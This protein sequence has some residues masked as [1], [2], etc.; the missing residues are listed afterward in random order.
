M[1]THAVLA[2][3]LL[4]KSPPHE[5]EELD[6]RRDNSPMTTIRMVSIYAVLD[7]AT[8]GPKLRSLH[9]ASRHR[10]ARPVGVYIRRKRY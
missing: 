9:S 2:C 5:N 3:I 1:K 10:R 4:W 8:H 7:C 6:I